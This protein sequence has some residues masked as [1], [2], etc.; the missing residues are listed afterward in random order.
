MHTAAAAPLVPTAS[1]ASAPFMIV[2]NSGSGHHE[3]GSVQTSIEDVLKRAGRAYRLFVIDDVKQIKQI[4]RNAVAEAQASNGIVVVAG[5]DGTIN[6]V[7]SE[8]LGSGCALGV[9]PQGTFNYFGR[10]HGI[11]EDLLESTQ[12]LLNATIEPVQVGLVND[13]VFLVNA[14]LG[15]YPQIL[16]DRE[17]YKRQYGRSRLVAFGAALLTVLQHKKHLGITLESDQKTAVLRTPTLFVGNNRLQM[18]QT[19]IPLTD[20]LDGGHLAAITLKPTGLWSLLWLGVRGALGSLGDAENVISFPFRQMTVTP[21]R[22]LRKR[23]IKVAT[24]GEVNWMRAPLVFR[25]SPQPLYLL[26]P[27][28]PATLATPATTVD[29][30]SATSA[31]LVL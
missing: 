17:A 29:S 19:G 27:L 9:L 10:T 1:L 24:D 22:Q 30:T 11:S 4:A 15:L 18:E 14:S 31:D 25:V 7:A 12:A 28:P 23:P 16:E 5:G 13:R 3:S 21:R 20:A 2:L 8:V 26:K 6:A